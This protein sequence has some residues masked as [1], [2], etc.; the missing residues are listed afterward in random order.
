MGLNALNLSVTV[1]SAR[2]T[3]QPSPRE[4]RGEETKAA[5]PGSPGEAAAVLGVSW[6]LDRSGRHAIGLFDDR[7]A[8]AAA[9]AVLFRD[10][11]PAIFRFLAGLERASD[12]G[13]T[14][15]E[16]VEVHRT[17]LTA[18]HPEITALFHDSLLITQLPEL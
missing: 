1:S 5:P 15:H 3:P 2:P 11:A 17:E 18:N 9:M 6:L 16:L 10:L 13:R 14:F 7:K 12:L 4:R 8:H